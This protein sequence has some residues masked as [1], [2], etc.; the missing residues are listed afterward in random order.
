MANDDALHRCVTEFMLGTCHHPSSTY[1]ELGCLQY[2]AAMIAVGDGEIFPSGSSA[3]FRIK[4]MLS[5]IGDVDVMY[6]DKGLIAIPQGHKPPTELP[7]SYQ[8][9]VYACEIIDSDKPGFVNLRISQMLKKE[10]TGRYAVENIENGEA[11][12]LRNISFSAEKQDA[13]Q[14]LQD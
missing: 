13:G 2:C 14:I 6:P 9:T 3:E 12:A 7:G 10:D 5:C 1:P 4:P 11:A 8:Y